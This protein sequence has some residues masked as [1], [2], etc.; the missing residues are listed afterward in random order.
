MTRVH[1]TSRLPAEWE[2]LDAVL[3][4]WP[5]ATSA[6]APQLEAARATHAAIGAAISRRTVL[7]LAV[8]A[9]EAE[10]S[11]TSSAAPENNALAAARAALL[12]AG[13]EPAALRLLPCP[14]NDTWARDF[15]P[16]T[17]L[18]DGCPRLLD[19]GFNGWGLKFPAN[20]DNQVT[21]RLHAQG[22]FGTTPLKTMDMILEGGSIESDG[23][24]TLLVT[25]NCLLEANR[26]PALNRAQIE[27]RL[28][29]DLGAVRVLWLEHGHLEGDDTDAHID[30]LARFCPGDTIAFVACDD[31]HDPHYTALQTMRAELEALRT[32]EGNPY[33]L[34][35]LPWPAAIYN[36]DGQRLPATYA[37]FLFVGDTVLVP[38]YGQPTTDAAALAAVAEACP[39]YQVEGINC[40]ALIEQHGSLHCVTMQIPQGVLP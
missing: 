5:P 12:A 13:A 23:A 7:L 6:W 28:Q 16:I 25:A 27:A 33:R 18:A 22:V 11:T 9:D 10:A 38:T 21:R 26:N 15:G 37:N 14:L 34:V 3:M 24:G 19:Y 20:H 29:A 4:A 39:G 30:T 40:R 17:V 8:A 2:P 32:L 31:P 36:K 35:P 1:P